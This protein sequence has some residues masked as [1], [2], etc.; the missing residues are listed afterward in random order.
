MIRV[1][2]VDDQALVRAG[3]VASVDAQPDMEVV[4]EAATGADAVRE[5]SRTRPDVVL[6][7]IR[8]P[9]LDGIDATHRILE[10]HAD[11]RVLVLT[12]FDADEYVFAALRAGASGFLLKDASVDE[13]ATAIRTVHRGDAVLSPSTTSR[14]IELMLPVL[15]DPGR[16]VAAEAALTERELEVARL[17]ARGLGNAEIASAVFLAEATVK[18]HVGRILAKLHLRDRVQI[19]IWAYRNGLAP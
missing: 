2:A 13:L 8:M 16:R 1:L 15:P 4:G 6:M 18:T 19:V 9:Q 17:V 5:A 11:T 3:A 12:T 7:D 10:R 14:L